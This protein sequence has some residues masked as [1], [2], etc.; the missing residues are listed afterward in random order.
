MSFLFPVRLGRR[1][2]ACHE[3][4]GGLP[5]R[6][7]MPARLPVGQRWV[8]K[9]IPYDIGPVPDIALPRFRLRLFGAVGHP[10]ELSWDELL[11]LPQTTVQADFH[12]VTGWSVPDLVWEGIPTGAIVD[13]VRPHPGVTWVIAYGREGYT[14][15]V[16]YPQFQDAHSLLAHRLNG[17]PLPPEHG[18]P[19]R[20][21]VPSLYAWKSA[22]YLSALEF[23]TSFRR[24]HWEARGYHDV[25]DPWREERFRS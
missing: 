14:T 4:T 17:A 25:G 2:L 3:A 1:A 19:L 6:A 8:E 9:P 12:C 11:R 10:G 18:A 15:N 21:V 13:L 24:G 7:M 23:L 5:Y 22:K 20:L 16:P